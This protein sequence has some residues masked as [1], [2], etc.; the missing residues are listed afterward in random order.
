MQTSMLKM[1][2]RIP[3][4]TS[5]LIMAVSLITALVYAQ[6]NATEVPTATVFPIPK[7][8]G[9]ILLGVL[10]GIGRGAIGYFKSPTEPFNG[11]KF[12]FTVGLSGFIG[13]ASIVLGLDYTQVEG[14]LAQVGLL[15]LVQEVILAIYKRYLV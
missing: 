10:V 4:V 2:Y 9:L 13:L 8:I 11:K 12:A 3:L 7:E 14:W 1:A 15:V 5:L 6:T